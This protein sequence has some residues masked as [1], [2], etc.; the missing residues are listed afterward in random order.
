MMISEGSQTDYAV[1]IPTFEGPLDLLLH[2]IKKDEINICDIPIALITRQYLSVLD[3]MKDLNLAVAG[4]F[5]VM[6]ATLIHIKSKML[7]PPALTDEEEEEGDPRAELVR[8]LLEYQRYKEAAEAMGTR[9]LE[10]REIFG[11]SPAPGEAPPSDEV[12]LVDLSLFDLIEALREIMERAPE[13]K[14]LEIVVDEL[15]VQDRMGLILDRLEKQE[16]LIFASLFE[17]DKTRPALIVTFLALLEL[18]RLKTVR[19]VQTELFGAIRVWKITSSAP[20]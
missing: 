9:E 19:V 10:W 1:K 4:E 18:I 6:A 7:L 14:G 5:L 15:S 11:R 2:L 16:S 3:L 8:R 20:S 17:E 12:D 13:R